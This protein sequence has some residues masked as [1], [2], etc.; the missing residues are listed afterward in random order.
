MLPIPAGS[1]RDQR[2]QAK[3]EGRIGKTAL[4]VHLD[5]GRNRVGQQDRFGGWIDLARLDRAQDAFDPL[6]VVRFTGGAF[7]RHNDPR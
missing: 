2:R 4:C 7:A 1:P 6:D 5:D 3:I